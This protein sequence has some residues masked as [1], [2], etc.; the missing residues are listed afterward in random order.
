[1]ISLWLAQLL[2]INEKVLK[3]VLQVFVNSRLPVSVYKYKCLFLFWFTL[4]KIFG[5]KYK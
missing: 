5:T 3:R 1:M 4:E 2:Y